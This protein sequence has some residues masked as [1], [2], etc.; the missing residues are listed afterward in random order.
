LSVDI[1]GSTA[2]KTERSEGDTPPWV[3]I[4][5]SFFEELPSTLAGSYDDLAKKG[6][7]A[8]TA[9]P[10]VWK[11]IGDEI[12]FVVPL[13]RHE[14]SLTHIVAFKESV[15]A[16]QAEWTK[17][18]MLSLRATAW[19]AGFPV[20][21]AVVTLQQDPQTDPQTDP[22]GEDYIGPSIDLGFRLAQF[23]DSR[24]MPISIELTQ[25]LLD[26]CQ[27]K[28]KHRSLRFGYGGRK[29]LKG[30]NRNRPYPLV[31]VD[32]FDG[33]Q[34]AEDRL[35][36]VEPSD[37][38]AL[39]EFVEE[40]FEEKHQIRRPFIATDP[41]PRYREVPPDMEQARRILKSEDP[42]VGYEESVEEAGEEPNPPATPLPRVPDQLRKKKK[43]RKR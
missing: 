34:T 32:R 19:T 29:T 17:K 9:Q 13:G 7:P 24:R 20:T 36:R 43:R 15:N 21:N 1:I 4:F 16:Y 28:S 14:E 39:A 8:T 6:F 27:L 2:F 22:Q 30:I 42:D 33:K 10:R 18:S 3:Q 5:E 26:A 37:R 11:F 38:G 35:L 12:V 40:F 23:A 31:W 25:L 41:N